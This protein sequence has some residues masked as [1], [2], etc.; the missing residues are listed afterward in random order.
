MF[1]VGVQ[2]DSFLRLL[3]TL[4]FNGLLSDIGAP[5]PTDQEPSTQTENILRD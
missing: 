2:T 3:L 4:S 1:S 5:F